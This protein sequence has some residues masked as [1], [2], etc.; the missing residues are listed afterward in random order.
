[1]TTITSAPSAD[2]RL[3]ARV[4][5]FVIVSEIVTELRVIFVIIE[6]GIVSAN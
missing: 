1:M 3:T 5:G 6:V 2:D 4:N